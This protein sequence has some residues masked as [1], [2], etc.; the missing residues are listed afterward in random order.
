MS[1]AK[2][3]LQKKCR[4]LLENISLQSKLKT[5]TLSSKEAL[6][7]IDGLE[8]MKKAGIINSEQTLDKVSEKMDVH[9]ISNVGKEK[10]NKKA[11]KIILEKSGRNDKRFKD[12]NKSKE[13][14][15][16]YKKQKLKQIEKS[17]DKIKQR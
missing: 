12:K 17:L 4:T 16:E 3:L 13:A 7:L 15:K 6:N 2:K 14:E 11:A 1:S 8:K 10:D 9:D 5:D